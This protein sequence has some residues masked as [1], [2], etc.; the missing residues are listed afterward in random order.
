[1][2]VLEE[3]LKA[4]WNTAFNDV[5]GHISIESKQEMYLTSENCLTHIDG[6]SDVTKEIACFEYTCGNMEILTENVKLF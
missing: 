4:Y 3:E 6:M 5:S 1:M 2:T